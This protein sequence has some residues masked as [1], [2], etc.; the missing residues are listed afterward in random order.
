MPEH[1]YRL[2]LATP[3]D[4]PLILSLIRAL[5]E[6]EKLLHEVEATEERLHASLFGPRPE[7]EVLIAEVA[8]GP[9]EG[10][11]AGFALFFQTYSTFLARR[12]LYL[13][14]LFVLPAHRGRGLGRLLLVELARIA[15]ARRC[16][17]LEWA[18]L[19]WNALAIRL[20]ERV[21]ATRMSEWATYRLTGEALAALAAEAA[22]DAA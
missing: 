15:T 20:Y 19:T 11:A 18:V 22:S 9:D 10:T 8:G 3:D 16:G 12:G 7:A 5:A 6:Y 1:R 4:V 21:G 2:R 17:R 14:D 13:E